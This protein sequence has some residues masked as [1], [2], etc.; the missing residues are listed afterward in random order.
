M[1][2]SRLPNKVLLKI[3]GKTL[4]ELYINRVKPS[5]MLDKIVIATT[6]KKEDDA[7]ANLANEIGIDVFRGSENDLIDRYYQCAKV[8]NAD[9]IVRITPDDPFVDYEVVDRAIN[10]FLNNDVDFVANHFT[11][12]F[13]E[14]LDVEIYSFKTLE[15]AWKNARL[16]SERE[17]IFP[18]IQN[19]QSQFKIINF[20][21]EKDYSHLRW[22]IDHECD[23]LMTKKIYEYLY[24]EKPVFLQDDIL[25][26]L[27]KYPELS[28]MNAHIRRK[29]GVNRSK[30]NDKIVK[31]GK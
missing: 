13:P 19:N 8:Y 21:Q 2:S 28:A 4:L 24:D 22:T 31:K 7:I 29:E 5:K 30:A 17:H 25:S 18:Y 16:L 27:E 14:G 10:I 26:L 11:P 12:T 1:G 6:K 3:K 20:S 23:Y 15:N 9:P